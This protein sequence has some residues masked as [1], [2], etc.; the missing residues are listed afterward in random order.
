MPLLITDEE[1]QSTG[2]TQEQ[3]KVEIAIH[4]FERD[5]LSL[6]KAAEFCGLHKIQMQQELAKRSIPLHYDL[7]MLNEDIINIREL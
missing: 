4:L 2:L 3:L 7:E 5:I 6:G 1:L